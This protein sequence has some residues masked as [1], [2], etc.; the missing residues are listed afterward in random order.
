MA[1]VDKICEFSGKFVGQDI[2]KISD[3]CIQVL[4][5]Y[6]KL[7]HN[8]EH[9]FFILKPEALIIPERHIRFYSNK[10]NIIKLREYTYCLYVPDIK[11]K[12]DGFYWGS[13][14]NLSLTKR[15][16]KRIVGGRKLNCISVSLTL[17][18][19]NDKDIDILKFK[20]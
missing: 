17:S 10:K 12:V 13:T 1:A 15:K 2:C 8:M 14:V 18:E 4:P 7:F 11:G 6:H 9:Y 16:I 3:I 19:L 20:K 5:I